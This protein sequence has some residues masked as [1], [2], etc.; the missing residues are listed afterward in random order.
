MNNSFKV[1]KIFALLAIIILIPAMY[2]QIVWLKFYRFSVIA[3]D[4]KEKEFLNKFPEDIQNIMSLVLISFTCCVFSLMIS[5]H[6]IRQPGF[7]LKI[8]GIITA[9]IAGL[10]LVVDLTVILLSF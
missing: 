6:T 5:K 7:G 1:K 9:L 10:L 2:I 8:A 3:D 4:Q